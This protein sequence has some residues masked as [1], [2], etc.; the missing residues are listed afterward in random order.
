MNAATDAADALPS[1][2]I[3]VQALTQQIALLQAALGK[4]R[5]VQ[6]TGQGNALAI[7]AQIS[8]CEQRIVAKLK[9]RDVII[10]TRPALVP[11][12]DATIA[13]LRTAVSN[14]QQ[15]NATAATIKAIVNQAFALADAVLHRPASPGTESF[16]LESDLLQPARVVAE[17]VPLRPGRYQ[18]AA[19]QLSIDLRIGGDDGIVSADL[20]RLSADGQRTW[21]AALRS[22]PGVAIAGGLMQLYLE[23]R[24]GAAAEG[25]M[26]LLPIASG[27]LHGTLFIERALD[28]LPLRRE[29]AFAADFIG[30]GR[31]ALGLEFEIE[32]GVA[33]PPEVTHRDARMSIEIA[34]VAG[35]HRNA[36]GR[37][38]RRTAGRAAGRSRPRSRLKP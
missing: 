17:A 4:L 15:A 33:G 36:P 38:Q 24:H 37:A 16:A 28:G 34:L 6:A 29:I 7:Q 10:N 2:A 30:A 5:Q 35:R 31:G 27:S 1:W 8:A 21:V 18:G 3:A 13:Q 32:T 19:A 26:T 9:E 12:S 23:D 20:F 11:P 25:T 14:L 22:V